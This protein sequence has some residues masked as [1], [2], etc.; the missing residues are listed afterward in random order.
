MLLLLVLL[1][2]VLVLV[3]VLLWLSVLVLLRVFGFHTEP[4]RAALSPGYYYRLP[5]FVRV[6]G[7][8]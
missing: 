5:S 6:H 1:V 2:L 3:L 7:T 8:E 4:L